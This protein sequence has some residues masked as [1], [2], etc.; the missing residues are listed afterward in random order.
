MNFGER[1]EVLEVLTKLHVKKVC[2]Y[3]DS[4]SCDCKFNGKEIESGGEHNG[5]PELR[6][7]LFVLEHMNDE[8]YETIIQRGLNE[9]NRQTIHCKL[10]D[11][12][13]ET[14]KERENSPQWKDFFKG[15][16]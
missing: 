5:C 14:D 2:G 11:L 10:N 7:A 12:K 8:E 3:R 15:V 4:I 16:K 9:G 13:W 1:K 6:S